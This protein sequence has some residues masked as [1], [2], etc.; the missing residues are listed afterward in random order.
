[1]NRRG[2]TILELSLA[3][4]VAAMVIAGAFAVFTAVNKSD[5]RLAAQYV[6]TGEIERTRRA[7]LNTFTSFVMSDRPPPRRTGNES[8]ARATP[9]SPAKAEGDAIENTSKS[10]PSADGSKDGSAAPKPPPPRIVLG[11]ADSPDLF[12]QASQRLEVVV[13]R[14]PV[15][16]KMGSAQFKS[17]REEHLPTDTAARNNTATDGGSQAIRGAFILR[18][19]DSKP[20]PDARAN[21]VNVQ[22]LW[23]VP[24][25]PPAEEGDESARPMAASAGYPTRLLSD[26]VQCR[27]QFFQKEE[28]RDAIEVT[29]SNDLPAYVKVTI[30]LANGTRTEWLLEIDYTVGAEVTQ[31]GLEAGADPTNPGGTNSTGR[32]TPGGPVPTSTIKGLPLGTP[33]RTR[34]IVKTKETHE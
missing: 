16:A 12:G 18:P 29:W 11:P 2:F 4:A 19:Q 9:V 25:P 8:T 32:V 5:R 1:M 13:S 30:E 15:P 23:W 24:L 21:S 3:S 31:S 26:I 10:D 7:F 22:E 34:G 17:V 6:H 27:W 28:W 33:T 20:A 14:S